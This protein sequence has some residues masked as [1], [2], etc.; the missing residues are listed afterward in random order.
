MSGSWAAC[1]SFVCRCDVCLG[2]LFGAC[3]FR[4]SLIW[5]FSVAW[6]FRRLGDPGGF[7]R[8]LC[9]MVSACLFLSRGRRCGLSRWVAWL[10]AFDVSAVRAVDVD[11]ALSLCSAWGVPVQS[12]GLLVP[13]FPLSFGGLAGGVFFAGCSG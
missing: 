6:G 4:Q 11:C 13:D 3:S 7:S 5:V 12:E 9:G 8:G 10:V 1:V 2:S